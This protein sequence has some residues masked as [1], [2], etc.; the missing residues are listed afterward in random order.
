MIGTELMKFQKEFLE[1]R[2]TAGVYICITE[3][4]ENYLKKI[5]PSSGSTE[6]FQGS[7]NAE[8]VS[9]YLQSVGEIIT[10]P[11]AIMGLLPPS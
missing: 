7:T 9:K 10:V 3:K 2:I 8:K 1:G 11:I 5:H 4:L 6:S